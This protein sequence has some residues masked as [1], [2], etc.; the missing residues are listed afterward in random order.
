MALDDKR[1]PDFGKLDLQEGENGEIKCLVHDHRGGMQK[2][3]MQ[4]RRV[5]AFSHSIVQT[6]P[7]SLKGPLGYKA[8]INA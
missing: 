5:P 7:K 1:W 8:T 3:I 2:V 4:G 6:T